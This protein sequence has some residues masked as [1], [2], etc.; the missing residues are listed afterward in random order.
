MSRADPSNCV[1]CHNAE[2]N[3]S[4]VAEGTCLGL[5]PTSPLDFKKTLKAIDHYDSISVD[6]TSW[7][8]MKQQICKHVILKII[9]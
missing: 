3:N 2:R 6:V 5:L 8:P 7:F 9:Y 1:V 4:E